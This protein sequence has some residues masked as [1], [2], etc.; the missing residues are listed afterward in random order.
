MKRRSACLLAALFLLGWC[1]LARARD[2]YVRAGAKGGKGTRSKPYGKL[3]K[4][5]KKAERGDVIHVSEGVYHGKGGCG[6]F[7]ITI[8][9]LTLVGGYTKDFSSR[10]PFKHFTVLERAPDYKGDWTGLPEGIIEGKSGTDHSGLIVDGFVLDSRTRNAYKPNGDINPKKS[11]KGAVF[12]AYGKNVKIRNCI[13]IN[14]YGDGIYCMWKGP[15]NEIENCFVINTFYTGISTRSAQDG[16]RIRISHTTVAFVWRQPGKGGGTAVFVGR[17]GETI[18]EDNIFMYTQAF[19]VNNG[20]GNED[21]VMKN[22]V[23][24]QCKEGYYKYCDDEGKNLLVW[25]EEDLEELNDDSESY[26]LSEAEGNTDSVPVLKVDKDYFEKFTNFVASKPGKLRLEEMNQWRRMLGLPLQADPA[27]PRKN[28]GMAYPREAVPDLIAK[29]CEQGV[30]MKEK[31]EEYHSKTAA[32]LK[33][34]YEKVDFDSFAKG[35]PGVKELA[36]KAVSFK[37]GLGPAGTAWL[38]EKVVSRDDYS[39]YKLLRPGESDFTLKYVY[40]YFLK[41][42]KAEKKWLKYYKK[43]SKYNKKGGIRIKGCAYYIGDDSYSYPVIVV[44]DQVKKK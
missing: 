14:P 35:A 17:Q 25:K 13:I 29:D 1:G 42:G 4:A 10:N 31:F 2:I 38:V 39:C 5:L 26:M 41:G 18:L 37:A 15:D 7:Y 32:P 44:V 40:G 30:R 34:S 24:F 22:N 23:F 8:P 28:W 19:A 27:S 33:L 9:N 6:G 20:F 12:K 3:W 43:R 11:W 21:T 16:S 36:G